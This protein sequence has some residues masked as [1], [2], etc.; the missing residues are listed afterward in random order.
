MRT[1]L[2]TR[3]TM[4]K[5]A[6]EPRFLYKLDLRPWNSRLSLVDRRHV[7]SMY[8]VAAAAAA[9]PLTVPLYGFRRRIQSATGDSAPSVPAP[10]RRR[11]LA[12]LVTGFLATRP[13]ALASAALAQ[14]RKFAVLERRL[15]ETSLSRGEYYSQ[16]R[17]ALQAAGAPRA[18]AASPRHAAPQ[19]A[20]AASGRTLDDML[21]RQERTATRA[22]LTTVEA[23]E[24]AFLKSER[25]RA[26]LGRKRG[27]PTADGPASAQRRD[28]REQPQRKRPAQRR[29]SVV[30]AAASLPHARGTDSGTAA[31]LAFAEHYATDPKADPAWIDR[32]KALR[33][34]LQEEEARRGTRRARADAAPPTSGPLAGLAGRSLEST[35]RIKEAMCHGVEKAAEA[36]ADSAAV[37]AW[38]SDHTSQGMLDATAREL[39]SKLPTGG[40]YFPAV[41]TAVRRLRDPANAAL[42][43]GLLRGALTPARALAMDLLS[44][45]RWRAEYPRLLR[46][47]AAKEGRRAIKPAPAESQASGAAAPP[48]P[49]RLG[50][51]VND[52]EGLGGAVEDRKGGGRVEASSPPRPPMQEEGENGP[53]PQPGRCSAKEAGDGAGREPVSDGAA[54]AARPEPDHSPQGGKAGQQP[55]Q[56]PKQKEEEEEEQPLSLDEAMCA[57]DRALEDC[58]VLPLSA[59]SLRS[60]VL[61]RVMDARAPTEAGVRRLVQRLWDQQREGP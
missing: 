34:Q 54:A 14:A 5:A 61:V 33:R 30:D 6:G 27:A 31:K 16:A 36:G 57:A 49:A 32:A 48:A 59:L 13:A 11:L 39:H 15:L 47:Q 3:P 46:K 51:A 56:E 9:F 38:V 12:G 40:A 37:A 41:A 20:P 22:G 60:A 17:A 53:A 45:K 55:D 2:V 21:T 29:P 4:V 58:G 7:I 50:A 42:T 52:K 10:H 18:E 19:Q 43:A 28:S 25:G 24:A 44:I 1:F 8:G 26:L 35:L 23:R